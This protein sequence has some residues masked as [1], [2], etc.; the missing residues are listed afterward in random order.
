MREN[1]RK[2]DRYTEIWRSGQK[3][4]ALFEEITSFVGCVQ[5]NS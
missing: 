3:T 2:R 5:L 4:A 1:K